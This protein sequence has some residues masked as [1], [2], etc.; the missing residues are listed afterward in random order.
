MLKKIYEIGRKAQNTN[1]F[2]CQ[3]CK[4]SPLVSLLP[5]TATKSLNT[6]FLPIF[7]GFSDDDTNA[8]NVAATKVNDTIAHVTWDVSQYNCDVIGYR[9]YYEHYGNSQTNGEI[10]FKAFT[11][12]SKV[13]V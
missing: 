5:S 13:H 4:T 2:F 12:P 11:N 6:D 10:C 7:A 3:G 8:R 1:S 9:V